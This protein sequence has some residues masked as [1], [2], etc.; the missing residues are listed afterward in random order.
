MQNRLPSAD[1]LAYKPIV[2]RSLDGIISPYI[3]I[4]LDHAAKGLGYCVMMHVL[5]A[6]TE[7]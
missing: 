5:L 4:A 3:S 6:I 2:R 7:A 1:L